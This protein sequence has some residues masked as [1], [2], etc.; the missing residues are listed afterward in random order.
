MTK[1]LNVILN[2]ITKNFPTIILVIILLILIDVINNAW[3]KHKIKKAQKKQDKYF[4]KYEKGNYNKNLAKMHI[5]RDGIGIISED[6]I[7]T[8]K[9]T[10]DEL[11]S[12]E[13]VQKFIEYK[14]KLDEQAYKDKYSHNPFKKK[15]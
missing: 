11:P 6:G 8:K 12:D 5:L 7:T 13:V 2:F 14:I 10:E 3:K 4:L 9:I 1:L 15:K